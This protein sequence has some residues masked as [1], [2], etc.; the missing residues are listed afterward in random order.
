MTQQDLDI[1]RIFKILSLSLGKATGTNSTGLEV[2]G[3]ELNHLLA[4]INGEVID[5]QLFGRGIRWLNGL[6]PSKALHKSHQVH[7]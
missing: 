3:I 2:S 4:P 6:T 5:Y 1:S 7:E